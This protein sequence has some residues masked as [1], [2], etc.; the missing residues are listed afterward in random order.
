MGKPTGFL[1]FDRAKPQRRPVGERLK[2][3]REYDLPWPADLLAQQGARCMDCGVPTCHG[4]TGCPLG[5]LIPDWNDLVY[6]GNWER[7]IEELHRTNNFPD[8]TGRVCPAPCEDACILGINADP[9]TIKAI[10]KAI[11]NRAWEEGWVKP[12][13]AHTQT[14]KRVAVVGSGPAGLAGAQQLAR[15]GHQV[16]VFEK[17]DRPGGLLTYG[18]PGFK[19]ER[20][21]VTRRVEQMRAEGVVFVLGTEVGRDLSVKELR[22]SFDAVLLAG[23]AQQAR[24]LEPDV[25]GRDLKGIHPAMDFLPQQNRRDL[26]EAVPAGEAILAAGKRVLILGGGD[27][28]ADCLGTSHRQGAREVHQFEI[29]PQPAKLRYSS[30]HEE[31]GVRRW[32][33]LAKGFQAD[34]TGHVKAL[35]GVELEWLPPEAPGGRPRMRE[36]PGTAFS[37]PVDLVLLAMGFLG[38]RKEGLLADLGVTFNARGAVA[39]DESYL[40]SAPGVFVAGDMT[41]GASL[42]VWAIWEGREAARNIHRYLVRNGA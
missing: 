17:S 15:L 37:Q 3:Y 33:V 9:V 26:G 39:R 27:T 1:E 14:W 22:G 13:P 8:V 11:V 6:R 20:Y 36:V 29:L 32:S 30:S 21:I 19:M 4:E 16:T 5:N 25:E 18:I 28:G 23:G 2:D 31:G 38:P 12:R 34:S 24:G 10:E 7:A 41:R 42:V 35:Q 40:T